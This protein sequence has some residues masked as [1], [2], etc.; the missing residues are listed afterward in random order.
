VGVGEQRLD[1]VQIR[2]W[3]V[4]VLVEA[5]LLVVSMT[6]LLSASTAA[7]PLEPGQLRWQGVIDVATAFAVAVAAIVVTVKAA[8]LV[9]DEARRL[10]YGIATVLPALLLVSMWLFQDRLRWNVLLP[11]LAW[12]TYVLLFSLPAALAVWRPRRNG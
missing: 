11:G 2:R 4:V 5:G 6:L 10:S 3:R 1:V 7:V 9:D 8:A 12:R